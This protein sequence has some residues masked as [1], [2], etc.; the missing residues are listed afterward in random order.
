M[1]L[2]PLTLMV[3]DVLGKYVVD[4][5]A[6][7][8]KEVGKATTQAASQLCEFVLTHLKA[9]PAD[10]KNAERFEKN[11]EGY[12]IPIADAISDK[13]KSDRDFAAQLSALLAEYKKAE[14]ASN[15]ANINAGSGVVASQGGI[16]AGPGGVAVAGNVKGDISIR[17]TQTR[18]SSE[19]FEP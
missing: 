10:A 19:R 6:T 14:S 9:D 8:L 17:N 2:D 18:K 11:P 1:T 16:A 3:V 15:L 4:Q 5:G 7:L 13:T 12:Q